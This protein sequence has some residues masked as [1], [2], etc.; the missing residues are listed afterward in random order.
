MHQA[1]RTSMPREPSSCTP[2]SPPTGT[3]AGRLRTLLV[4]PPTN[5]LDS[6]GAWLT[7]RGHEVM[8][9]PSAATVQSALCQAV[10]DLVVLDWHLRDGHPLETCHLVRTLPDGD[11]PYIVLLHAP[12]DRGE[13]V[14][15]LEAGA[16][17]YIENS[18]NAELTRTR[19]ALIERHARRL[20]QAEAAARASQDLLRTVVTT[21]PVIVFV[22]DRRGVFTMVSGRGLEDWDLTADALLGRSVFD[23]A[24]EV[25]TVVANA[26]RALHGEEFTTAVQVGNRVLEIRHIPHWDP[27]GTPDGFTGVAFDVTTHARAEAALHALTAALEGTHRTTGARDSGVVAAG[28]R[29]LEPSAPN[30]PLM[31]RGYS[32]VHETGARSGRPRLDEPTAREWEL[33]ELLTRGWDDTHIAAELHLAPK[34]VRNYLSRLYEKL[35]IHSRTEAVAWAMQ[36]RQ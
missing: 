8:V 14:R 3:G 33:L 26:K 24:R 11:R 31:D 4:D 5:G 21:T 36:R 2:V 6:L 19:L 22:L 18:C 7:R 27:T 16:D 20:I 10:F 17:D 32:P 23:L 34:T 28:Q 1:A 9:A 12:V 15:A 35:E 13:R 30:P 29:P 25:P